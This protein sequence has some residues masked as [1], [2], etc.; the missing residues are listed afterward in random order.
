MDK[1]QANILTDHM[2]DHTK[3]LTLPLFDKLSMP[4]ADSLQSRKLYFDLND[5][6]LGEVIKFMSGRL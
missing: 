2:I 5:H 6:I 1:K 3:D 4:L